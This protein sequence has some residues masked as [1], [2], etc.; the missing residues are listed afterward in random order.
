MRSSKILP[1]R[2]MALIITTWEGM[3][4]LRDCGSGLTFMY[5]WPMDNLVFEDNPF[6]RASNKKSL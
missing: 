3:R 5:F 2:M 6:W 4:G 1:A